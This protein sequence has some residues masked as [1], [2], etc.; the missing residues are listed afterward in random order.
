MQMGINPWKSFCVNCSF[1]K[2]QIKVWGLITFLSFWVSFLPI[3]THICVSFKHL[4]ILLGSI[5]GVDFLFWIWLL[6]ALSNP[7]VVFH[8][9]HRT[10]DGSNDV[11]LYGNYFSLG[12][13]SD[14]F[15]TIW[16]YTIGCAFWPHLFQLFSGR[17]PRGILFL[18]AHS[19]TEIAMLQHPQLFSIYCAKLQHIRN[20]L[21]KGRS[22]KM[23]TDESK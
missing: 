22:R 3:F 18:L 5:F 11:Y 15:L 13:R 14:I 6:V 21:K 12:V 19:I 4:S 1:F 9:K 17:T 8:I 2:C 10:K 23:S 20:K 16:G 7:L